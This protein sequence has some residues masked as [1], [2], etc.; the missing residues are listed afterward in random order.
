MKLD[1]QDLNKIDFNNLGSAPPFA[2]GFLVF[3]A[4]GLVAFLAWYFVISPQWDV[5]EAEQ[6]QE[7]AKRGEFDEKQRKAVN[8]GAYRQQMQQMQEAFKD[9]PVS[10]FTQGQEHQNLAWAREQGADFILTKDLL[11][12]PDQWIARVQEILHS[13]RQRPTSVSH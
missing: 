12:R 3:V 8:L 1:L 7:Q 6:L 9:L 4:C 2:K 5:L 10:L 13:L 11:T